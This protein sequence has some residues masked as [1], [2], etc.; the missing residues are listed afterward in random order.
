MHQ[1]QRSCRPAGVYAT[2]VRADQRAYIDQ[3][4]HALHSSGLSPLH[5]TSFHTY[6]PQNTPKRIRWPVF[7]GLGRVWDEEGAERD[8]KGGIHP[9]LI[10]F[11]P[12]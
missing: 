6:L 2:F 5:I 8:D 11:A 12:V 9:T 3:F 4:L 7:G 10:V 1:Y